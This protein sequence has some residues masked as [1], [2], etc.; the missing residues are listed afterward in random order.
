MPYADRV[1]D[2]ID[3]APSCIAILSSQPVVLFREPDAVDSE[4]VPESE[5]ADRN[6][7]GRVE[8]ERVKLIER[9]FEQVYSCPPV[10]AVYERWDNQ[11]KD[12]AHDKPRNHENQKRC[13][14]S[15]FHRIIS[16]YLISL[17]GF[18]G[19]VGRTTCST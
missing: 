7:R 1:I 8:R 12:V 4:D 11:G 14:C 17:N 18:S 10:I 9:R 13:D 15:P 2:V 5:H 3:V 16:G 19:N 6:I